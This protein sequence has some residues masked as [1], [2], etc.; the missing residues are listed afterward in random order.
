MAS[1][2]WGH[3]KVELVFGFLETK[4]LTRGFECVCEA[5]FK[6]GRQRSLEEPKVKV[7]PALV[8]APPER[9]M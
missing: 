6:T 3:V 1:L 2:Q 4:E 8:L 9:T 5:S 7:P